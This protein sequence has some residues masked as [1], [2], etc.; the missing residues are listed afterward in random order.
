MVFLGNL[1][2][3]TAMLYKPKDKKKKVF[4][5]RDSENEFVYSFNDVNLLKTFIKLPFTENTKV[6]SQQHMRLY[7]IL[8]RIMLALFFA[9]PTLAAI[10]ALALP[11]YVPD[12]V[13][14]LILSDDA[15]VS[16]DQILSTFNFNIFTSTVF[17]FFSLLLAIYFSSKQQQDDLFKHV[18]PLPENITENSF[19]TGKPLVI[20][21]T[22]IEKFD[23]ISNSITQVDTGFRRISFEF[24]Q[25]FNPPVYVTLKLDGKKYPRIEQQ[26]KLNIKAKKSMYLE[27]TGKLRLKVIEEEVQSVQKA[28]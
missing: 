3:N 6:I 12:Q 5:E 21:K 9:M 20:T 10:H 17:F 19:V 16:F 8:N 25:G 23:S 27:L 15:I 18:E 2:K 4:F 28:A 14:G 13:R 26:I 1:A 7:S 22:T 24:A 11:A